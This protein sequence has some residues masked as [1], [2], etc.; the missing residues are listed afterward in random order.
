MMEFMTENGHP[1][2]IAFP[3]LNNFKG[4]LS[5]LFQLRCTYYSPAENH[6]RSGNEHCSVF[7]LNEDLIN[8]AILFIIST[9]PVEI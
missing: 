2:Q 6:I 5:L 4:K 8:L 9:L 3:P 7:V 1:M